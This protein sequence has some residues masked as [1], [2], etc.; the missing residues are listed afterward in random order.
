MQVKPSSAFH[1]CSCDASFKSSFKKIAS[2]VRMVFK[3]DRM[4]ANVELSLFFSVSKSCLE[5]SNLNYVFKSF[6]NKTND[7]FT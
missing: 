3:L 2:A 4:L 6:P 1:K 5:C 7:N